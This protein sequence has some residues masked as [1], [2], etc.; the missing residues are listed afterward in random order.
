VLI[1]WYEIFEAEKREIPEIIRL[2]AARL[3]GVGIVSA[4]IDSWLNF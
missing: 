3:F 1:S 4:R 2:I